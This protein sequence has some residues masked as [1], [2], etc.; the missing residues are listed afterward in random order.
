MYAKDIMAKYSALLH[1]SMPHISYARKMRK[2]MPHIS[3]IYAPHIS[4]NSAYFPAYFASKSSAYFKKIL[5]YK[6]ASLTI[7]TCRDSAILSKTGFSRRKSRQLV[8]NISELV[9]NLSETCSLARASEQDS[10][11]DFGLKGV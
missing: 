2:N 11:M 6:P 1:A 4:P 8:A 9:R 7:T 3:R 10:I 5:R